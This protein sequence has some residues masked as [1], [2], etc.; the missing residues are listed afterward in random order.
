MVSKT[1]PPLLRSCWIKLNATFQNQVTKVGLTPDQ[2]TVLRWLNELDR[3]TVSQKDLKRLMFT[4]ANN[5]AALVKRMENSGLIRRFQH[6]FDLR[7][8][9]LATTP[10][11]QSLYFR[12]KEIAES[13]EQALLDGFSPEEKDEFI[14]VLTK[15]NSYLLNASKEP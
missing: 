3:E 13:V 8:K 11:G 5:I 10:K 14:R 1:L 9:I 12:G 2:Y 4:D 6:P 7:K 15:T